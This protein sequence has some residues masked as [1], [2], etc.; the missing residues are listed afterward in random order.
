MDAAT[1]H[2]LQILQATLQPDATTRQAAEAALEAGTRQPGFASALLNVVLA[3]ELPSGLRQLAAVVLK[4]TV[5][6]HW[7][8][9]AP[10]FREPPLGEEEK[11]R[12]REALPAGLADGDSKLRTAVAMAIAGIAKW[13]VPQAWPELMPRLLGSIVKQKDINLV[14]GSVRC[15]AMFLDDVLSEEQITPTLLPELLQIV[16]N[17]EYGAGLQ[18]K[19]L[20]LVHVIGGVLHTLAGGAAGGGQQQQVKAVVSSM[21]ADWFPELLRLLGSGRRGPAAWGVQL[22]SL[23]L[24]TLLLASFS[25]LCAPH[26]RPAMS[27]AWAQFAG[28]LPLYQRVVVEGEEEEEGDEEEDVGGGEDGE[29][30][31][32]LEGLVAQLLEFVLTLVGNQRYQALVQG[33]MGELLYLSLGYMQMTAAQAARWGTSPN[34]YIADEDDDFS[35]VRAACEMLLDE[36][37]EAFGRDAL[38][39]LA[40]ATQRRLAEAAAAR[41]AG[42]PGWWRAR[43]AVLLALGTLSERLAERGSRTGPLDAGTLMESVLAEDLLGGPSVPPFLAGRALWLTARLAPAIAPARRAAFLQAAV[44]GLAPGL[45]PAVQIGA[46]RAVAALC[47]GTP[48]AE[49]QPHTQAMFAGLCGMLVAAD[50]DVMH[51]VLETLAVVVQADPAGAAQWEAHIAGPTLNAWISHVVDP[52]LAGDARDLLEAMAGVPACLPGLQSRMLPTLCGILANPAAHSAILVDG[53]LELV[54]V[55]LA[56]SPPEVAAQIHAATTPAVLSLL[57]HSDDAEVLRSA[58]SYLR[59]L[60]Q[61]GGVAVLCWGGASPADSLAAILQAVQRLLQPELEDH[62]CDQAPLLPGLLAALACKLVAAEDSA[63]VQSLL[64][65]VAQLVRLDCQQLVS[66]LANIALEDGRPALPAVLDKWAER[67]I[68]VRTAYDIKLTTSALAAILTCGHPALEG[69]CVRGAR[70]DTG[71]GI[72]TRARARQQAEQWTIVP[73]RVKLLMLLADAYIECA[74]QGG[75]EEEE[76]SDGEWEEVGSSEDEGEVGNGSSTA[77]DLP[78]AV[79]KRLFGIEDALAAAEE[80]ADDA[81]LSN[82]DAREAARRRDDPVSGIDLAAVLRDV[83]RGLAATEPAL[84]QEAGTKLTPVQRAV[85]QQVFQ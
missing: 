51:L 32:G 38:A 13:D 30:A 14:S 33:S 44:A 72:R 57:L 12:V 6:E 60:L 43:E 53:S 39:P 70:L 25:R 21:L 82:V 75:G 55:V 63:T 42:A 76:D 54:T 34:E 22:E 36:L 80:D 17:D 29:E 24:M 61:V 19:A 64:R 85:V 11:V 78:G 71:G 41:A 49:L 1:A 40:A 7:T 18:R 8:F 81:L 3:S 46:C 20:S 83:F 66:C 67:Q 69:V 65:V 47:R 23:R 68:E 10:S 48:P 74:T 50:E 5:R 52:L 77:G 73:L 45:P 56:P 16:R 79:A 2:L 58:T 31:V 62:A 35:S 84:L 28:S 59:T 26:V 9:E 37:V 4:K 27:A 15:L